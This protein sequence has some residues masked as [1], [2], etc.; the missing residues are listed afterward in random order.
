MTRP[1]L[2]NIENASFLAFLG[3][4]TAAFLVLLAGFIEPILW[5]TILALLFRAPNVFFRRAFRGRRGLAALVTL[6]VILLF[7]IIPSL[8]VGAAVADEAT[9]ILRDIQAREF[10]P[11]VL[12]SWVENRLPTVREFLDQVGMDLGEV[13]SS[14][15]NSAV[16][17][18][19][20]L[21][22]RVLV[23]GQNAVRTSVLLLMMLYL[24]FFLLRDGESIVA[25]ILA[26]LPL[27][28]AREAF[29]IDK[30][31]EVLR[32][33]VKG[34]F[35]VGI[36]QGTLGGL[37]FAVLG[38][39]AAVLWGVV[40]AVLS[41]LPIIGSALIWVPAAIILASD[42]Q[43]GKALGL[44][45]FGAI[46]ISFVDNLLRPYLIGRDTKMPDYLVLLTTLGGIGFFGLSGFVLGP[47][48]AAVF[49]ASWALFRR[50]F[51]DQASQAKNA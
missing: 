10:D 33:T 40:M 27:G 25:A 11:G 2:A 4:V 36:V 24:L 51:N 28:D 31:A 14:L 45:I 5:A 49:L 20:Y 46:V 13:R 43:L 42:G 29:L 50:E 16:S 15:S 3:L 39:R 30:I 17:I 7:V 21:A 44:V 6:I 48:V 8:L 1:S 23:I 12:V 35:A 38:I 47:A 22:S 9:A 19:Q 41:M 34:T 26:A 32:A 18:S 37:A